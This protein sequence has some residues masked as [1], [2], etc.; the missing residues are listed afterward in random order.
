MFFSSSSMFYQPGFITKRGH[1]KSY[2]KHLSLPFFSF[3]SMPHVLPA[4]VHLK[5]LMTKIIPD[6]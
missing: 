6:S 1:I 5:N 3:L 4:S 2:F